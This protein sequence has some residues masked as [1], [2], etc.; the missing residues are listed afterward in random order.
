VIEPAA[1]FV[2]KRLAMEALVP[3]HAPLLFEKLSDPELYQYLEVSPPLSVDALAL[4][5]KI[6][7]T[8]RSPDGRDRWLNWAV[9]LRDADDY[10]GWLQS[11]V[12]S[13]GSAD[14]AYIIFTA[15]QRNGFA[16]EACQGL[17]D[18]L[19]RRYGVSKYAATIDANNAASIRVAERLGMHRTPSAPKST[20]L[21][22][23]MKHS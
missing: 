23:V 1:D 14:I 17:V 4:Q 8:R 10:V 3:T 5:Y 22:F 19:R 9:R 16:L 18:H 15:H 11:T 13:S 12:Y 21:R 6:W 20:E 2:T 7:S